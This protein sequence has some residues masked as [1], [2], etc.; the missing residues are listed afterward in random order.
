MSRGQQGIGISAAALYGQL[1]TGQPVMITSRTGPRAKPHRYRIST[2]T[3]P[4]TRRTPRR[5]EEHRRGRAQSRHEGHDRD[6]G[7]LP[8]A[9]QVGRRSTSS[10]PR[11][12]T[13]TRGSTSGDA[14]R[15]ASS[16]STSASG[17]SCRRRRQGDQAAPVRRRAR[18]A[19]LDDAQLDEPH[20][21]GVSAKGLLAR[22]SGQ[23]DRDPQARRHLRGLP[24]Q[25]DRARHGGRPLRGHPGNE[26]DGAAD[27]LPRA[28]RRGA[29]A[30]GPARRSSTASSSRRPRGRPRSTAAT[31][32]RSRSRW[33][34]AASCRRDQPC[35]GAA[36]RQPRPAALP[37]RRVRDHEGGAASTSWRNYKLQQPRGSL[38]VGPLVVAV[39]MASVW[40]PFT[41]EA[42]EAIASL[43]RDPQGGP[44]RAAGLRAQASASTSTRR[45]RL[46][47]E[48]AQA[49]PHRDVPAPH[50][51]RAA[52]DPA[53]LRPPSATRR[54]ATSKTILEKT[55]KA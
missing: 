4:R 17:R 18:R 2:S 36:L 51:H 1:T 8:E 20:R 45:R 37:G 55:R 35:A 31:R 30:E 32:S 50:Q 48:A 7:A 13:R 6:R 52:G 54:A 53:A 12:P 38:P 41:S 27:G 43:R 21:E 33:P 42:K 19:D 16:S 14:R 26:A 47:E 34:T 40:V 24:P 10:R 44:A 25:D 28:D 9:R 49:Q 22:V 11:W 39:H 15:P 29:A 3:S 46:A 5:L 23:G